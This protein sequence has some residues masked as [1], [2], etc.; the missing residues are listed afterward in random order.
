[1]RSTTA[2][3]ESTS[4]HIC[5]KGFVCTLILRPWL[6]PQQQNLNELLS[7]AHPVVTS[8]T[9]ESSLH[10]KL[11]GVAKE[12]KKK[13]RRCCTPKKD[14]IPSVHNWS[15][16]HTQNPSGV[17]ARLRVWRD[18]RSLVVCAYMRF[19]RRDGTKEL[20]SA[21][22]DAHVSSHKHTQGE[23]ER[24]L[25]LAIGRIVSRFCFFFFS[26]TPRP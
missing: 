26:F 18:D 24:E 9:W 23:R 3:N 11:S 7:Q 14:P 16:P 4:I 12:R 17:N 5:G 25:W 20:G 1:M 13:E 22:L 15:N 10:F 8:A 2:G 19:V 21:Q 6:L